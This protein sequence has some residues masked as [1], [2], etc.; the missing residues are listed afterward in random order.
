MQVRSSSGAA[1]IVA[2]LIG[3]SALASGCGGSHK[4]PAAAKAKAAVATHGAVTFGVL[5][6][7]ERKGPIGDRGRDLVDGA[8]MAAAQVNAAGGLLGRKLELDVV[9]DAC[10][11]EVAYEAAKTFG[12]GSG[13][14]GVVGGACNGAA[15][16]EVPIVDSAGMPFLVTTANAAS[17]I[18]SDL[19]NTY[20]MNG[21]IYEQA[22]SAV[23]WMNYQQAQRLAVVDDTTADSQALAKNAIKLVDEAPKLVS[24][25]TVKPDQ[26]DMDVVAKAAVL[27]KPNFIYWTGSAKGGGALAKALKSAGYTGTFTASAASESPDFLL[28]AGPGGADGAYITATSTA[29]NTPT[30]AK[31]LAQFKTQYGHTPGL[32]AVQAYD[33][34]RTLA[35]TIKQ[36]K[37]TDDKT[38]LDQL[39]NLNTSFTN[40]LGVVR[41]SRD[42]TLLYDNRIILQVKNDKF[43]WKRSLRTDSLQ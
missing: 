20:F 5:A 11:P 14:A 36:G 30:A 43:T 22:L 31:W 17:L 4:A 33:A 16:R 10:V 34:V 29:Q 24:L 38:M 6:P 3:V 12:E 37:S 21:T 28:A 19:T 35:Q 40:F 2:V 32:D 18:T 13:V 42:H 23:F 41:F 15:A 9:D 39:M 7:V 25:Q 8:K 26:T 27:S 1:G